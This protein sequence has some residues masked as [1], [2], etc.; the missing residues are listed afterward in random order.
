[1]SDANEPATNEPDPNVAQ[2]TENE[3]PPGPI[4]GVIAAAV[5]NPVTVHLLTV[6]LL[7]AGLFSY[8]TMPR[9]IFPDFTRGRW[10]A[11][12]ALGVVKV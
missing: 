3:P 12:P 5:N 2:V 4:R 8:F 1:M 9:E 6:F 11:T 10:N 7:V